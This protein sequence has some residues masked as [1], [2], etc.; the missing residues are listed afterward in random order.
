MDTYAITFKGHT[1][2][3]IGETAGKAKYDF[4]REYEIGESIDFGDF[5]KFVKCKLL[6]K[7]HVKD[8]FTQNIESFNH[9]KEQQ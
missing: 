7:F 8:L 6:H 1:S 3:A 4:F 5:V 9:I 2:N